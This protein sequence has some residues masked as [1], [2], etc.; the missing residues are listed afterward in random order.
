LGIGIDIETCGVCDG[1][2]RII[3]CVEAPEVTEKILTTPAAKATVREAS[4][5]PPCRALPQTHI[6][7]VVSADFGIFSELG[8][9]H[10]HRR[11]AL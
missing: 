11:R 4:R 9:G 1:A 5:R 10:F 7:T 6:P 8:A 2:V 3:L